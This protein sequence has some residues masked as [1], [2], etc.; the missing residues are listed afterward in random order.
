MA[1]TAG[2]RLTAAQLTGFPQLIQTQIL[3]ATTA[4]VTITVPAGFNTLSLTGLHRCDN[5]GTT[6]LGMQ[7][8]ADTGNNYSYQNVYGQGAGTAA[9]QGTAI[10]YLY[11]GATPGTNATANYF[12][13]TSA[14]IA[15]PSAAT[16]KNVVGTTYEPTSSTIMTVLTFGTQWLSTA[17]ITSIKIFPVTGNF[18]AGSQFSLYGMP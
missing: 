2:Q 1:F 18:V 6:N 8:N 17:T 12:A 7:L 3:S 9:A 15:A 11:C 13:T 16:F 10:G 4:S 14:T 5:T